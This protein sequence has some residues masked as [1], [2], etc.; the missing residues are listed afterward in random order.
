MDDEA[1]CCFCNIPA[2]QIEMFCLVIYPPGEEGNERTQ[3]VFCQGACL[4]KALHPAMW[5]HPDLLG[6]E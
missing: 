4:D 6:D 5:R 1:I 2:R 3:Q